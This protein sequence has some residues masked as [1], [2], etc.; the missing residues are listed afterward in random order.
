MDR[1]SLNPLRDLRYFLA[2]R[3]AMRAFEPD[4]VLNY[5][6]KPNL[7]GSLAARS[8]AV[9]VTVSIVTGCEGQWQPLPA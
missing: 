2:L 6:I 3:R 7:Y 4:A 1:T 9:P 8:L 5:T